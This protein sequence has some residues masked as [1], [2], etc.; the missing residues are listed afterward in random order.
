MKIPHLIHCYIQYLYQA[1]VACSNCDMDTVHSP[2]RHSVDSSSH[3][4][5]DLYCNIHWDQAATSDHLI[6]VPI[7]MYERI[8]NSSEYK[9]VFK[10]SHA[11]MLVTL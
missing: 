1:A 4:L 6:F 10:S 9:Y 8:H 11:C 3:K 5:R 2:L 7:S